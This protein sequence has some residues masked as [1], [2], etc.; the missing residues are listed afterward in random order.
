MMAERDQFL[1]AIE[2]ADLV[3]PKFIKA[4]GKLHRFSSDGKR[5]D[6]AGWYVFHT[7]DIPAGSF[8]CF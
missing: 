6:E 7:C 4:D 1:A 8:G 5:G 3:P 2:Q